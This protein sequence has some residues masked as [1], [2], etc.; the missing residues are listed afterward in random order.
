MKNTLLSL[1]KSN[2]RFGTSVQMTNFKGEK[3]YTTLFG[4][5][6]S[7]L[8]Y[9]LVLQFTLQKTIQLTTYQNQSVTTS[10]V[11]HQDTNFS[12]AADINFN[13]GF[14]FFKDEKLIDLDQGYGRAHV[15]MKQK[16]FNGEILVK[17]LEPI[18]CGEFFINGAFRYFHDFK[19]CIDPNS[20]V[21]KGTDRQ[22]YLSE[23]VVAVEKC[24]TSLGMT[25][26][27]GNTTEIE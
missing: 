12:S 2:D 21:L 16:G 18:P 4:G 22:A 6:C 24:D 23:L 14:A 20:Y 9:I 27:K 17:K 15:F 3:E 7:I 11:Y 13:Y 19:K 5:V 8:V 25:G 26:C 1:V 10:T